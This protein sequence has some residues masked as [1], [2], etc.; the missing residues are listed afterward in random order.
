MTISQSTH[1][2]I[3]DFI[4]INF[5]K[6]FKIKV[7]VHL[8]GGNY[9]YFFSNQ[10]FLLKKLIKFTL[11]NTNK[12][13][14]L[15]DKLKK[16]FD[17]DNKLE[18]KIN[19]INNCL[20]S[21]QD[22]FIK[23]KINPK[24]FKILFLSNLI[25]TKGYLDILKALRFLKNDG[26]NFKAF[27]CGKFLIKESNYKNELDQSRD[28]FERIKNYNLENYVTY[29]DNISGQ[30]KIDKLIESD[31][32]ILP[33]NYIHEGQPVSIIE[34]LAYKNIV[35]TTKYKSIPDL[36]QNNEN[37]FFVDYNSP[38]QIYVIIKSLINDPQSSLFI[39]NNSFKK[40]LENYTLD[41]HLKFEK[42]FKL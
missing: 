9:D 13:V 15:G 35:I 24:E 10:N 6:F 2:F 29:I 16:M 17:F 31:F 25:V 37:G 5:S 27:F 18:S 38:H 3:R 12:I 20:T 40:Y 11:N 26:L 14:V 1:G 4:F 39:Q 8:K 21:I 34:A 19:I 30:E 33:T 42:L 36:I 7:V 22:D 32:F 41:T 28:F 23:K